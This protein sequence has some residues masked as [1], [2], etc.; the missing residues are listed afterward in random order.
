MLTTSYPVPADFGWGPFVHSVAKG[1]KR[2]GHDIRVV[3]MAADGPSADHVIDS[4]SVRTVA[5][6]REPLLHKEPGILPSLKAR[7]WAAFQ[8]PKLVTALR[9]ATQQEI[10]SFKPD[11]IHAHW[12]LPAG[13]VAR[14]VKRRTGTPYV[15]TGWGADLHLPNIVPFNAMI[16]SV[17]KQADGIS[18]VSDHLKRRH[19]SYETSQEATVI[20]N[21]IDT[22]L[23]APCD[24]C[25]HEAAFRIAIVSRQINHK[26]V[27]EAIDCI[28]AMGND[29]R[30][31]SLLMIGD[32]PLHEE[33][34]M[35]AQALP[36]KMEIIK[37]IP[38]R[39]IAQKLA[40]CDALL[41]LSDKEGMPT[42][43]LEAMACGAVPITFD[44][45]FYDGVIDND[46]NG[47]RCA[48]GSYSAVSEALTLLKRDPQRRE[49][50]AERARE[51]IEEHFSHV[52]I[53]GLY[54]ELYAN[55]LE[56]NRTR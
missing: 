10:R 39:D 40:D 44:H 27:R 26:R 24:P 38:N 49:R 53:A 25:A 51:T 50:M 52:A 31:T 32:G 56:L 30:D 14:N 33:V 48:V 9:K 20:P 46:D 34:C 28:A 19:A 37:N 5:Y 8:I 47:I 1:V 22:S 3:T 15:V 23:F 42:A 16:R 21:G 29:L 11:M 43:V 36:V 17:T 54:E 35:A 4:I 13:L 45:G 6:A 12:L 2:R 41:H 18:V 55:A 7:P